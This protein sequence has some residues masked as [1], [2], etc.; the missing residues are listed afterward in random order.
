M[1]GMEILSSMEVRRQYA[2]RRD[3]QQAHAAAGMAC[4]CI[5]GGQHQ[6][7]HGFSP[8]PLT[9]RQLAEGAAPDS[10]VGASSKGAE[11]GAAPAVSK[12]KGA[13]LASILMTAGWARDE[14]SL[15]V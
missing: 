1:G 7:Q 8:V 14:G 15:P 9:V 5:E 6:Q 10:G 3:Q 12:E 4:E 2:C 13:G 11:V